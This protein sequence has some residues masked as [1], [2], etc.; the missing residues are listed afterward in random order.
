MFE[1]T[2]TRRASWLRIQQSISNIPII[3][4]K[5]Q[6]R[7]FYEIQDSPEYSTTESSDEEKIPCGHRQQQRSDE[8]NM[9]SGRLQQEKSDEEKLMSWRR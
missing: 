9:P 8:E 2:V 6:G 1:E 4:R 5:I 7:N 3:F